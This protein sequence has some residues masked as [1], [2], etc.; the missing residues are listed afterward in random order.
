MWGKVLICLGSLV[1]F[2]SSLCGL[3]EWLSY[4]KM[5]RLLMKKI[6]GLIDK[7]L[8]AIVIFP[9]LA[10]I[11]VNLFTI[12]VGRVGREYAMGREIFGNVDP[13]GWS[14]WFQSCANDGEGQAT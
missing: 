14:C 11:E 4:E 8:L 13:N 3:E 10:S 1:D 7:H 12:E 6:N 5:P 9:P 2:Y